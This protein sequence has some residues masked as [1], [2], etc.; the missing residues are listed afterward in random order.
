MK[1]IRILPLFLLISSILFSTQLRADW[2]NLTGAETAQNIAEIYVMDDHV[3]IQLEVYVGDLVIG[4]AHLKAGGS[5]SDLAQRLE[6]S[7]RVAR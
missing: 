1:I 7:Q 6:A 5:S 4:N 3:K 2:I